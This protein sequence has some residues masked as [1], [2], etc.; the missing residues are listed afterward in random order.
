MKKILAVVLSVIAVLGIVALA[1]C[2]NNDD[3]GGKLILATSADFPPYEYMEGSEYAG[4]DIE[5]AGLIAEKLG[6]ELV[7]ENMNFNSVIDSIQ[8]GKADIGMSGITVTEKRKQSVNFSDSYTT[9]VQA[10]IV[11]ENSPIKTV[12][13]IYA[14]GAAYKF[15]VQL[16]TTGDI[17]ISGE[18]N[19]DKT[20]NGT[21]EQYTTG[22]EAVAALVAGKIDCV[23]ID[24]EPAK[25]FVKANEGLKVLE[26]EYAVEDYAI[27]LSKDNPELLAEVNET[28]AEIKA[29]GKLNE[30]ITKYIPAE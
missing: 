12:D 25:S 17:Y 1:G 2:G 22:A 23:V 19:T 15:G 18:I 8:A 3:N 16:S 29:N 28:L 30:I 26:T 21:V 9:A 20:L 13:D 5:I 4:I 6:A 11:P 7:V 10:I 24:N 27:A 14:D